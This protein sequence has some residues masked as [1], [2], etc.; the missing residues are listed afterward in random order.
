MI[1]VAQVIV[2]QQLQVRYTVSLAVA[3]QNI[4]MYRP[5]AVMNLLQRF[6]P[7]DETFN[8]S[9]D[10]DL[11]IRRVTGV[12]IPTSHEEVM[13]MMHKIGRVVERQV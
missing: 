9:S 12:S 3:K 5:Q 2:E 10:L 8:D 6:L 7:A 1:Q 11:S 13:T 4:H